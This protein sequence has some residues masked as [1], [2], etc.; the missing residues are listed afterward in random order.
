MTADGRARD[1]GSA[2][3]EFALVAALM[4]VLFLASVQLGYALHVR[5]TAT[6]HVIEGAR[7]GAR[8]DNTPAD[9]AARAQKLLL[10]T[11]PA[12]YAAHVQAQQLVVG[13][14]TVVEVSATLPL[15]L[16]GPLGPGESMT[17]T[18]QAFAE[19]QG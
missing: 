7:H 1:R 12:Q 16:L 15:P 11:L 19:D 4:S 17:V 2:V 8:A 3:A 5:N 9:G 18:G 6:A 14:V 10:S 13:G